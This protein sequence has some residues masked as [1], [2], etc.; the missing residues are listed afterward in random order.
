MKT[1][2]FIGTSV[3]CLVLMGG[4]FGCNTDVK[5]N[6]F[7]GTWVSSEGYIAH[8]YD[9]TFEVP[10]YQNDKGLKGTYSYADNAASITYTEITDDGITW[11]SITSSEASGYTRTATVS[12]NKLTWGSTT[13][14]KK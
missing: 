14:T 3:F 8:F 9:S 13:Y 11:R 7:E 12:G 4:F 1:R 2:K 6:P 5:D 10:S